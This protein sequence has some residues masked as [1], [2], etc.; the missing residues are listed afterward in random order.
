MKTLITTLAIVLM[1]C[2]MAMA[3]GEAVEQKLRGRE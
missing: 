1:A 2:T 3:E